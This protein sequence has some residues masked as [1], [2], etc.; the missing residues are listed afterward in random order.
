MA[1]DKCAMNA[2]GTQRHAGT[3]PAANDVALQRGMILVVVLIVVFM[4]SLAGLSFV[5]LMSTE[6]KAVHLRGKELQAQ[7]LLG[8]GEAAVAA[9]I[10]QSQNS[11]RPGGGGAD[12]PVDSEEYFRGVLVVG[13]ERSEQGGR[14]SVLSPQI[15]DDRITAARFGIENES[16]RLNLGV[17]PDWERRHEGSAR[18][19]LMSLPGMTESI[20]DAILDWIDA[21]DQ[22]RR[23]GAEAQYYSGL[24]VP[25]LPRGAAPG[26]VEELLLV[27]GVTRSL[28]LGADINC[29]YTIEPQEKSMVDG[30]ATATSRDDREALP[31][32]SLLTVYSAERNLRPD[33]QERIDL[34]QKDLR[35]L[36]EQLKEAFE[37]ASQSRLADF[38]VLYRQYGPQGG[39]RNDTS[40]SS[41]ETSASETPTSEDSPADL[42]EIDFNVPAKFRFETL[43]DLVDARIEIP[44]NAKTK[45]QTPLANQPSDDA[46]KPARLVSPLL[47]EPASLQDTLPK[48]LDYATVF[49]ENVIHGRVNINLAPQ[50]VLEGI[51]GLE[52]SVAARIVASRDRQNGAALPDEDHRH[53]TWLLQQGLVDLAQMKAIMPFVT[54]GGDVYRAQIVGFFDRPGPIA[55]RGP[56]ARA[57][58]VVDATGEHSRR[59]YWKDLR[60]LGPGFSPSSLGAVHEA[61]DERASD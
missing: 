43:L 20:A 6:N 44:S 45:A 60:I 28:L 5:V 39:D 38:I 41:P 22:P 40:N 9:F 29:N 52:G 7:C 53:A 26:C 1:E 21:D 47:N 12:S 48:L 55:A 59:V 58:V 13:D 57:E 3:S 24:G 8:S 15:E 14:F 42:P 34:N 56:I 4:I 35:K 54:A 51:P 27:K 16:A 19:A 61:D 18:N 46:N 30:D 33:G 2:V 25:Y 50:S 31:W 10:E 49:P 37:S 17:L 11:R 23:F 32:A 36:H